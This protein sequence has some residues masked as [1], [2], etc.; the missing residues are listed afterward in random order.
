MNSTNI[1]P[2]SIDEWLWV[3]ALG[4]ANG[5]GM[6]KWSESK[7]VTHVVN[8]K[9]NDYNMHIYLYVY[10]YIY[11]YVFIYVYIFMSV[12]TYLYIHIYIYISW[13]WVIYPINSDFGDGL[14]LGLPRH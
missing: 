1:H 5:A 2:K 9:I 4:T 13:R 6:V 12:Y 10:V 8:L 11:I 14:S 7:V 3:K